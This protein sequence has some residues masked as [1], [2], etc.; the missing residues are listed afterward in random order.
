MFRADDDGRCRPGDRLIRS[1]DRRAAA[2]DLPPVLAITA[3]DDPDWVVS[4]FVSGA[5]RT[6]TA[7]NKGTFTETWD[8]LDDNFMPVPPGNYGVKGI[9]MPAEVWQ[10][11]GKFHSLRANYLG[12]PNAL[13]PKRGLREQGPFI[14]GDQCAPGMGDIAVGP[15][16]VAIFYWKFLENAENAYRVD[17]N[18]PLGPEQLLG[19]F[20]SGGTGGG[21]YATTDGRTVWCVAPS[22]ALVHLDGW[23][24]RF[25]YPPFRYR[26]DQKPFGSDNMI[27]RNVT[28]T[29]GLVTG[30]AAWQPDASSTALLFVAERGRM[31]VVDKYN[32]LDI[33]AESPK[34]RVNLLRVLNGDTA[35]ELS[36]VPVA[37]PTALVVAN[38]R[39]YL[40]EKRDG[41]FTV[42]HGKPPADG[43]LDAVTW[44]KPLPLTGLRDPRDLAVDS[45]GNYYVAD[46]AIN[47]ILCFA[48]DG[49]L[50]RTLGR[51]ERQ[52]E[53]GYDP[54]S[55][56][57][58]IRAAASVNGHPTA[59][60]FTTGATASAPT[61]ASP[62]TRNHRSI[63]IC[64]GPTTPS[65][66]IA[67]TMH[68]AHGRSKRSGTTS[69]PPA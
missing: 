52:P 26:A 24:G 39:L 29:A 61:T 2:E 53:G 56:M 48:A 59:S 42:R 21:D 67:S 28:L 20:G 46:A 32:N 7:E 4:T 13:M 34:E 15:D 50:E 14:K 45:L 51:L 62:S 17:L 1:A 64:P 6:V 31:V 49:K 3:P 23:E 66:A 33:Y 16:G 44:T 19:G 68:P 36:R 8:G 27:R 65:S 30:L 22:D 58:P 40:L 47:H 5:P 9:F 38:D 55:F 11:D 63:S 35:V 18:L 25:I 57:E 60:S 69:T 43:K 12:G 10:P 41:G 37:E 54:N